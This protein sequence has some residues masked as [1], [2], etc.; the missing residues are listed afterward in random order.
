M[1][2]ELGLRILAWVQQ[3]GRR[4]DLDEVREQRARRDRDSALDCQRSRDREGGEHELA[5]HD[6]CRPGPDL[7]TTFPENGLVRRA[8]IEDDKFC[9][10]QRSVEARSMFDRC[11]S[12]NVG[13]SPLDSAG[14]L[15]PFAK[16]TGERRH[17]AS[18][19]SARVL[20][21]QSLWFDCRELLTLL[22]LSGANR[23]GSVGRE[24]GGKASPPLGGGRKITRARVNNEPGPR[25]VG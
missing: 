21:V 16:A 25:F 20:D 3:Q 7:A 22:A 11:V 2:C 8:V 12:A 18:L 15:G 6:A 19:R 1:S 5:A 4:P 23:S 17:G 14:A 13:E 9:L 10:Q 24:G